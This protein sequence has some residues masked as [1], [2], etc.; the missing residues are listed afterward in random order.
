MPSRHNDGPDVVI[1]DSYHSVQDVTF[2][3][4]VLTTSNQPGASDIGV[5]ARIQ[6][7]IASE[8]GTANN[9]N[10]SIQELVRPRP[11]DG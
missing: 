10:P 11:Y 5:A 3:E 4:D 7:R 6:R 2:F 1:A 8:M 9:F